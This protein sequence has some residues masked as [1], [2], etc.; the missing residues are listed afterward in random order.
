MLSKKEAKKP[1]KVA[2]RG[3][4]PLP[5]PPSDW[6]AEMKTNQ[7]E[8]SRF[9]RLHFPSRPFSSIFSMSEV[10]SPGHRV[11]LLKQSPAPG[12]GGPGILTAFN[13]LGV[14]GNPLIFWII[15][16]LSDPFPAGG[17]ATALVAL[18]IGAHG[19]QGNSFFLQSCFPRPPCFSRDVVRYAPG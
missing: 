17:S 11:V 16:W 12:G 3:V 2:G 7:M 19:P 10:L 1:A 9:I 8:P 5:S 4:L 18:L 15:K 14:P 13:P 6:A